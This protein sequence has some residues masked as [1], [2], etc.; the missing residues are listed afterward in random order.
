M[1][2]YGGKFGYPPRGLHALES[3][4]VAHAHCGDPGTIMTIMILAMH[5]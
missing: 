1:L 4:D 2:S 5:K 3:V